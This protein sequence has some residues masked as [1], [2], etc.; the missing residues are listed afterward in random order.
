MD[1]FYEVTP[2]VALGPG[3]PE[4]HPTGALQTGF[5]PQQH[6]QT[7]LQHQPGLGLAQVPG[8][9]LT[10]RG[11][12]VAPGASDLSRLKVCGIPAGDF[13]DARLR[14]LF[15]LCGK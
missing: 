11:L 1:R 10:Q 3:H 6:Q 9:A 8:T 5:A 13:T 14:Q 4:G 12:S 7:Q 2:T 15:E